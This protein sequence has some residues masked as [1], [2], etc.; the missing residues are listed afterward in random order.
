M[1]DCRLKYIEKGNGGP[2]EGVKGQA[3]V[4]ISQIVLPPTDGKLYHPEKK[5]QKT[6]KNWQ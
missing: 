3:K 2:R 1:W 6:Q 4:G 5:T